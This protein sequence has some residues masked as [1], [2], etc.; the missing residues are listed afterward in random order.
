MALSPDQLQELGR[1]LPQDPGVYLMLDRKSKVIYVGKAKELKKRVLSYFQEGRDQDPK[2]RALVR[3]AAG[4]DFL[5]TGTEKEALILEATLIKRH[6]PRY[7]VALRDDKAYPYIRLTTGSEFPQLS[8]VRRP[9]KDDHRYFGPYVSAGA[10]RATMRLLN[11]ILPLRKCK[12]ERPPLRTRPCLEYQLGHCLAPCTREVD[13][14][15]YLTCVKEAELFLSGR[16]TDISKRLEKAMWKAAQ[17]E[18]FEAAAAYRDRM[19]AVAKTLERQVMVSSQDLDRDVFGLA[20]GATGL[21]VVVLFVRA[22][23]LVGSRSF[24]IKGAVPDKKVLAQSVGQFYTGKAAFPD[25][26]LLPF[27]CQD[28]DLLAEWL[29][30]MK[31][32][33][34]RITVP[35]RGRGRELVQ[36]AWANAESA[37]PVLAGSPEAQAEAALEELGRKLGLEGPPQS[38]E[39]Y[40]ISNLQKG[41]PVGAMVRFEEGRPARGRYR[42]YR[43]RTVAGQDDY[44]MLVE[45]LSRRFSGPDHRGA[46]KGIDRPDL[47]VIDGGKGQLSAAVAALKKIG[48]GDQ[49]LAALAKTPGSP[50]QDRLF[51]PG[52]K[53][54]VPLSKPARLMLMR[55]RD[56][57]HRRAVTAHRRSRAG[58]L[59]RS[60]LLEAPGIGPQRARALLRHLG[61]LSAVEAA[62]VEELAQAPG[63]SARL[64]EQ[65]HAHLHSPPRDKAP[66]EIDTPPGGNVK[67]GPN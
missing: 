51:I 62:R 36:R 10:A 45:V 61:S 23:A 15:L 16:L 28:Q 1:T 19:E 17:E 25:Q 32:T 7:N 8:I 39:G 67:S 26:V 14:E 55:L 22:G 49:P 11:R 58:A 4:V 13:P 24:F 54:P 42:N 2:L 27:P 33:K 52:R 34:V 6:R 59:T 37:L 48:L 3:R 20:S 63:F 43:I 57:T 65:V 5:V 66:K 53:N 30:E 44:A 29:S 46:G 9:K 35:Q 38:L 50:D 41:H 12:G 21:A 60:K 31:G 40:D 56:E 64:A 47:I 18:R